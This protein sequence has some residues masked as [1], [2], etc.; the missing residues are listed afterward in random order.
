M[1]VTLVSAL[2]RVAK[3]CARS[4]RRDSDGSSDEPSS[5]LE[6]EQARAR[7]ELQ[8]ELAALST[9]GRQI[10][11]RESGHYIHAD[12]PELVVEAVEEL[13]RL[14]RGAGVRSAG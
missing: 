9:R 1:L 5:E 7:G 2:A 12:Q 14:V 13:V 3:E 11:A 4:D 8:R 6:K 10:I